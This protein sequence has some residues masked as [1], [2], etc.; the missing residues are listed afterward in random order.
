[1]TNKQGLKC[2]E[3]DKFKVM[4][5]PSMFDIGEIVTLYNQDNSDCPEFINN[6]GDTWFE[7]WKYLAPFLNKPKYIN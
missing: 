3:G 2:K 5:G 4:R 7:H 1:M 6:D